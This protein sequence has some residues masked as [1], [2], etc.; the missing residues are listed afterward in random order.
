MHDLENIMDPVEYENFTKGGKFTVRRT[1][2]FWSAVWSDMLIEQSLMKSMK[3][4]GGLT[5]GRGF[6]ESTLATWIMG[7]VSLHNVCDSVEKFCGVNFETSEQHVQLRSSRIKRD[8]KDTQVLKD[9]FDQHSPFPELKD[10][11]C[12]D[13]GIIADEH[14]DC[15]KAEELGISGL[16]KIVDIDFESLKFQRKNRCK[17]LSCLKTS[18]EVDG[19]VIP[20]DPLLILSRMCIAKKSDDELKSFLSFELAPF[21]LSLFTEAGMRKTQKSSLYGKITPCSAVIMEKNATFVVDGGFLLHRCVWPRNSTFLSIC[22]SYVKY[23]KA[24]YSADSMV[25]FD[26]YPEN[27]IERNTE[28]CRKDAKRTKKNVLRHTFQ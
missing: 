9:W 11:M 12:I 3:T 17:P 6:S 28:T 24:H 26:G 2:K 22:K 27:S 21:P 14:I 16:L 7:M 1:D 15:H 23:V 4:S 18:I 25:I 20:I 10:L 8:N 19:D 13:S 5:R